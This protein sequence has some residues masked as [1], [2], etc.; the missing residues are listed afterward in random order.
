MKVCKLPEKM[1]TQN[2]SEL[3]SL[4]EGYVDSGCVLDGSGVKVIGFLSAQLLLSFQ[5]CLRNDGYQ[6]KVKTSTKM[7]ETLL[8]M[9]LDQYFNLEKLV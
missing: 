3:R 2:V 5:R 4:L 9:G 7:S 1:T 8:I 6:V